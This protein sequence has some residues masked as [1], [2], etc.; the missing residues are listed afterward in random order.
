MRKVRRMKS[1]KLPLRTV[2]ELIGKVP[3]EHPKIRNAGGGRKPV[4]DFQPRKIDE[5]ISGRIAVHHTAGDPD[6]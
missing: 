2:Q 3:D 5:Q 1:A 6:G 4:L